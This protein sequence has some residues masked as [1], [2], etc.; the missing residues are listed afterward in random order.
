MSPETSG[1]TIVVGYDGLP[2]S[3]AAVEHAIDR[4]TPNG[5]LVLVHALQVPADLIG[6]TYYNTSAASARC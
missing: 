3:C 4:A 1:R 6:P 5:R 2:A